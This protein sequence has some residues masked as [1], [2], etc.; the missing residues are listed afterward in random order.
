MRN[1]I[2]NNIHFQQL[3]MFYYAHILNYKVLG[4]DRLMVG[5]PPS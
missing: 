4:C 2:D 5:V 3:K 1:K